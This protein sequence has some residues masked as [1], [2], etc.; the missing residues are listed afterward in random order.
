[1]ILGDDVNDFQK[2]KA[3]EMLTRERAKCEIC[4]EEYDVSE[5]H[6]CKSH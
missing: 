1:M 6:Q 3:N 4:G 5:G 2:R